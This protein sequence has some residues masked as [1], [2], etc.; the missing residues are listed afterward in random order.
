M[1]NKLKSVG[2]DSQGYPLFEIPEVGPENTTIKTEE[3]K[4]PVDHMKVP[5]ETKQ[6]AINNF[7]KKFKS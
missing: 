4:S 2:Y 1:S 7:L 3:I 5:S 6:E